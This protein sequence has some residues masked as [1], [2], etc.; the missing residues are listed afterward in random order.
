LA[1]ALTSEGQ[2]HLVAGFQALGPD[3]HPWLLGRGGSD[4][5]A[6]CIAAILGAHQLQ[7]W[8]DV[9]GL[10]SA[11]PRIVPTARLLRHA[12]YSEAQELASMGAKVLHPP[13]VRVCRDAEIPVS[14]CDTSRPDI[15]GTLIGPRPQAS[16]A[17]VK[18]IVSR[19]NIN[20]IMMENPA[21]WRQVGFLADAFGVFKRHGLSVDLISTSESSVTVS[22]DPS[23]PGS[24]DEAVVSALVDELSRLCS[25]KVQTG[26]ASISLVG[27]S[28]RMLLGRLTSALDVL[29]GQNIHMV[30][31]SA[32]DLNLTLVV[33]EGPAATLVEALHRQLIDPVSGADPGFGTRWSEL[34]R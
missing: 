22:L 13:S 10:F 17:Q 6:A 19:R 14:I 7:V 11:D 23:R 21:M 3:G 29:E 25:V 26:C 33:D 8:T 31:Q 18:G 27:N 20:L 2:A 4:T 16:M 28:I 1:R 32:N 5:S 34:D 15:E 9:P 30:T 12:S 24:D